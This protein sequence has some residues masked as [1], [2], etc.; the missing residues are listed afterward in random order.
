MLV[1]DFNA[2]FR[3]PWKSF[4]SFLVSRAKTANVV[5]GVAYGIAAGIVVDTH[6]SRLSQRL[7]LT[8]KRDAGKIEQ[9][10]MELVPAQRL[11][12]LF[13]PADLSRPPRLQ[14]APAIV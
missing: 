2:R 10:L 9:E 7:G 6:V 11:D 3:K 14:G 1:E 12:H 13:A 8:K 5:L 4:C